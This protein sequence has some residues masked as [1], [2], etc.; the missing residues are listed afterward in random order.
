MLVRVVRPFKLRGE[1][2]TPGM[3]LNVPDDSMEP[4]RGKV[5][6]VTP[7]DKMQDEYFTLLT[8]WW[9]ID[10]DPT[11]TDEEARGLLVQLD[12]LYQGLH[13]SGCKVPVRLPVERKAA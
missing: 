9:Q 2:V 7:M 8:R 13:R 11:A 12:V 4:L 1:I 5:E 10:D 6:F 3:L